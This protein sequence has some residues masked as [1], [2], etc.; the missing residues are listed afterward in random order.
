M[1][2]YDKYSNMIKYISESSS[3]EFDIFGGGNK[4]RKNFNSKK[5]AG[6]TGS[7]LNIFTCQAIKAMIFV[8]FIACLVSW[9]IGVWH[10]NFIPDKNNAL[11]YCGICVC[12]TLITAGICY[13]DSTY[14][15]IFV[16]IASIALSIWSL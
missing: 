7:L 11:I 4:K 6:P 10:G 5:S 9:C 13:Y 15:W 16:C 2:A 3:G 8:M 12:T 14:A 1:D